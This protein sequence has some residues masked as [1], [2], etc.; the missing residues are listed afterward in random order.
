MSAANQHDVHDGDDIDAAD[1]P[2]ALTAAPF[3]YSDGATQVFTPDGRTTFV[4]N[5]AP[6]TGEWGVDESG[7]FWSFW[8]PSYRATYHVSWIVDAQGE[9]A[10]VRFVDVRGG[11]PSEGRYG[12]PASN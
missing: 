7:K 8:P 5:G 6:T 1:I 11:A 4:E 10:G 9:R 3:V 2:E 12:A